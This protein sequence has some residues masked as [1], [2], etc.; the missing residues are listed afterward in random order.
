MTEVAFHLGAADKWSY[1]CRLLRKAVHK[2]SHVVVAGDPEALLR[3]SH[4]LWAISATDF[5]AHC[6]VPCDA[7]VLAASPVV[8]CAAPQ[9][10][11]HHQALLN[12]GVGVPAGFERFERLIEVVGTDDSD[13]ASARTRWKHYRT[14]GYA[15]T[16]HEI[17]PREI[18]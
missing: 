11:P 8:L 17:A 9:A 16:R 15:I 14:R 13:L 2:G 6:L 4:G 18:H 3:L 5:V 1:A 7:T 12:L 10:A